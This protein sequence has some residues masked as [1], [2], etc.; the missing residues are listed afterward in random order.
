M[1]AHV[2][3]VAADPVAVFC[4]WATG[5][6]AEVRRRLH[7][8]ASLSSSRAFAA[9]SPE[10]A[11]L[12]LQASRLAQVWAFRPASAEAL[13]DVRRTVVKMFTAATD[14]ERL[15]GGQ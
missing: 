7:F 3:I 1:T 5:E 11:Q 10:A 6:E 4:P 2:P 9:A 15:E 14:I 12:W 13:R 8:G